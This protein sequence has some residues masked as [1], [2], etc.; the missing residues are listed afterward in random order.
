MTDLPLVKLCWEKLGFNI[1]AYLILLPVVFGLGI[2]LGFTSLSFFETPGFISG[3]HLQ[4]PIPNEIFKQ[5]LK[6]PFVPDD[7]YYGSGDA[8]NNAWKDI[9]SGGDSIWLKNPSDYGL[10]KGIS[11]PLNTDNTDERFYVLSNLHQLH[12]V[13]VVRKR[14]RHYESHIGQPVNESEAIFAAWTEHTDH[15][16]E[17]LRLSITCGDF[18]VLEPASP[19]GTSPELTAGG[20]G[21]GVVHECIDFDALRK[22]QAAK[23]QES[24]ES[25]L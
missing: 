10:P 13:N 3:Q 18:L 9:T 4:T 24:K 16:F 20:L 17:Y 2:V 11:D 12:C 22:W 14:F 21:W 23:R 7:K 8:A 6:I 1:V 5:R 15:C 25:I 19:P